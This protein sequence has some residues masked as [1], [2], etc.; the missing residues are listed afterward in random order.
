MD[1]TMTVVA[2]EMIERQRVDLSATE[3]ASAAT[4]EESQEEE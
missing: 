2:K 4:Y 1:M 3:K